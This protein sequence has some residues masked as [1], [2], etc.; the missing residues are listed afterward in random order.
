MRIIRTETACLTAPSQSERA[1]LVG[2][3]RTADNHQRLT[4]GLDCMNAVEAGGF[5]ASAEP[6]TFPLTVAAWN[7][8]RC[9]FPDES[10]A[11]IEIFGAGLVLLSEMD[12]GMARTGQKNTTREMARH[13]G[14]DYVFG[15][16]FLELGLGSPTERAYCSDDFNAMGFHGNALMSK[17]APRDAFKLDLPG[18]A[19][20][21]I[22]EKTQH[23][24]GDRVAVGAIVDTTHGPL[25]AVSTH[26][27]SVAD[28]PYRETQLAAIMD[29]VEK[30]APGLPVIIGGDLN[31]GNHSGGDHRTDP[32][33]AMA[34]TRGYACHGGPAD[35]MSTRPSLIT[36]WPHRAMK[37][38]WFFTRGMRV[39][40]SWLEPSLDEDGK[41][42]SDHDVLLCQ[43]DTLG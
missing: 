27:E 38:D 34:E 40:K 35:Q 8:E 30:L 5:A 6:L 9:L 28:G 3:A 39:A 20:W 32:L 14:M 24:I 2:E 19:H 16:E 29:A 18:R 25:V 1:A 26:L 21:F 11:K 12:C 42:L 31:T 33:F 41:P 15:V 7:V 4:R 23:R 10:A 22:E 17:A 37:L 13:L 36:R 43:I